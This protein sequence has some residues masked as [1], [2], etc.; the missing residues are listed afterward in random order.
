MISRTLSR[1]LVALRRRQPVAPAAKP[2]KSRTSAELV[3][4][5]RNYLN[6]NEPMFTPRIEAVRKALSANGYKRVS[7]VP[8]HDV[9]RMYGII[10]GLS[11]W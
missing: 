4:L 2:V 11:R 1:R 5:A 9:D 3:E 8:P 7:A 6:V 10:R